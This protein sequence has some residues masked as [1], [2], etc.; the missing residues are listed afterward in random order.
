MRLVA[1]ARTGATVRLQRLR[2]GPR[3]FDFGAS[4][5]KRPAS[6]RLRDQPRV[7]RSGPRVFD[8]GASVAKR[9]ASVRHRD[10]PRVLRSGQE[11]SG[12]CSG[13]CV[14]GGEASTLCTVTTCR[15][16]AE[17]SRLTAAGA[18]PAAPPTAFPTAK[19]LPDGAMDPK[20][21][22]ARPRASGAVHGV[23]AP[24]PRLALR[25]R[26]PPL[27]LRSIFALAGH[28]L[29]AGGGGVHGTTSMREELSGTAR[30]P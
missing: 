18:Y 16:R 14:R 4:V 25:G 15:S 3:V 29:R 12:I 26:H 28:A 2:S 8:F 20:P 17:G 5:A 10:Q 19:A 13:R 30:P 6:V 21:T 11:L 7:L 1:P 24:C 9:P 27:A 22:S 23:L